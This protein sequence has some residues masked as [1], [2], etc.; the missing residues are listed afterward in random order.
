[1]SGPAG[2]D[3]CAS[4]VEAL[5]LKTLFS[6]LMGKV[7]SELV[8]SVCCSHRPLQA[9]KKQKVTALASE[10]L[11]HI[12]GIILSLLSNLP[13]DST[14]RMRLL[15]KF[16]ESDY[17]KVDKLLET[18]EGTLSRLKSIDAEIEAEKKVRIVLA[19]KMIDPNRFIRRNC[20]LKM[21]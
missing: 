7:H 5:G 11:S 20:L 12:L 9:S 2:S 21:A 17:A 6:A 1:M 10:D 19:L 8:V 14:D 15:A 4:F 16:V 18:R 3:L 13:S